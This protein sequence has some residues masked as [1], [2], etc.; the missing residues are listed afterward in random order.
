[1]EIEEEKIRQYLLDPL[2]E[3]AEEIGVALIS[4]VIS[5]ES[6]TYAEEGLIEDFLDGDLSPTD[7]ERFLQNYLVSADRQSRLREI[8]LLRRYVRRQRSQN[9]DPVQ[10]SF[11]R[12]PPAYSFF[13][14]R[15]LY[16][17][18]T[19]AA[20]ALLALAGW[21]L[22]SQR[23]RPLDNEIARYARLNS[24]GINDL[25]RFQNSTAVTLAPGV[26]RGGST[27]RELASDRLTSDVV[28]RLALP[29]TT[30]AD[31]RYDLTLARSG[32]KVLSLDGVPSYQSGPGREVRVVLPSDILINGEYVITVS[33]GD[34]LV[35]NYSFAVH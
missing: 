17:A 13:S 6:L 16:F 21:W 11:G 29:D 4:N 28:F 26:S 23:E 33:A 24:Q 30:D 18:G 5:D 2:A 34:K 19:A 14:V 15:S 3:D 22:F 12:T 20:I 35:V 8:E 32:A 27:A 1:M 25:S 7:K 10:G 31:Q 9:A